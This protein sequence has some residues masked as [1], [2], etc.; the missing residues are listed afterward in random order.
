L[1][2]IMQFKGS[3]EK[4]KISDEGCDGDEKKQGYGGRERF[5]TRGGK[6][7][8]G[9]GGISKMKGKEIQTST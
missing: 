5:L 3:E 6:A 9:L 4:R 2:R 8:G 1:K 7:L